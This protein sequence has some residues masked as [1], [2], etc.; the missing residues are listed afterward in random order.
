[1]AAA[2]IVGEQLRRRLVGVEIVLGSCPPRRERKRETGQNEDAMHEASHGRMNLCDGETAAP[3]WASRTMRSHT[4]NCAFCEPRQCSFC[5]KS[6]IAAVPELRL[7]L[8]IQL[9][10]VLPERRKAHKAGRVY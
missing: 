4:P 6:P 3:E 9:V 8:R 5:M 7:K 2:A 1:M 10:G